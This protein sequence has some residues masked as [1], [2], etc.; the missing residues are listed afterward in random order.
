MDPLVHVQVIREAPD[1]L[2]VIMILSILG[3]VNLI[4]L[5]CP[6]ETLGAAVLPGFA[7]IL[8]D[9]AHKTPMYHGYSSQHTVGD[10]AG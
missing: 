8:H 7:H 5:D 10:L 3:K 4:F 6:D 2:V 1:L 9:Y